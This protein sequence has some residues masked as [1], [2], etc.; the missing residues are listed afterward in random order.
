GLDSTRQ[1]GQSSEVSF[2]LRGPFTRRLFY[3]LEGSLLWGESDGQV[4]RALIADSTTRA[5]VSSAVMSFGLGF[6]LRR[7]TVLSG[8]FPLGL[9]RV[10]GERLADVTRDPLEDRRARERYICSHVG[11]QT[12]VWRPVFAS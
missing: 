12:G 9:S 1:E 2:R 7:T 10:R 4:R 11:V 3:G 8:G 6:A 5:D